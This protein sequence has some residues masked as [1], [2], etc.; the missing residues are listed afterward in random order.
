MRYVLDSSVAFK[1]EVPEPD[2]DKADRL[3]ED[4]RN[5]LLEVL[6]PD[7]FPVELGHA[8]YKAERRKAIQIGQAEVF[9]D[10]AKTTA[11]LFLSTLH[12][13]PKAIALAS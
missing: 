2:S 6:A 9:W 11:P 13:V 10:D 5:A 4:F 1:W 12:L 3:R 8:F 7:I